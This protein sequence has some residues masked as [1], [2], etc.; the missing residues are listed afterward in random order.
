MKIKRIGIFAVLLAFSVSLCACGGGSG[1]SSFGENLVDMKTVEEVLAETPEDDLVGK[2]DIMQFTTPFWNTQ[3]QYNEGFLLREDGSGGT[4][5]VRL[6]F[7]AAHVLEVRSNDL[8]T[9]YEEGK[10]YAVEDGTLTV[11]PGSAMKAMP[12]SEFFLPDGAESD[13]LYNDKA[14]GDEGRAVTVDKAVLYRYRYVVTYIRTEVYDGTVLASKADR[15]PHF[16]E[17]AR[18]GAQIEMLYVGDSIGE[19]AGGSGSFS[20]L[21]SLTAKGIEERTGADVKLTN[22]SVGGIDSLEFMNVAGGRFDQINPN[23]ETKARNRYA[24]ME[25]KKSTADIV[26]IALG[27]NDS[28]ADRSADLFR[29]HI[30]ALIDYFRAANPDVSVVVVSSMEI[31]EKIRRNK[32]DDRRNLRIHDLGEYA[33]ALA[34][35]E[36]EYENLAFADVH[37]AQASV[38]ERKYT[39]DLIAD[40]LNH[41]SDY[42][43]RLYAQFLLQTVL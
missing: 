42:M 4:K 37:S 39:E 27:A 5:P 7:P 14:G 2:N 11:L 33:E 12:D 6:M 29:I 28:S 23:I 22:C 35:L 32:P 38:L 1:R 31:N 16:T 25:R 10:D 36:D 3:I 15:I 30:Q 13:W 8:Q 43:S 19:G 9:L 41:P 40:N 17:K 21:A 34:A 24:L 20:D 26:F 18:S